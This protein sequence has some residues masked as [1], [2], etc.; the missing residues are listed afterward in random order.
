[1]AKEIVFEKVLR[2][3]MKENKLSQRKT[4]DKI[5][6]A[7]ETVS[8]WLNTGALPSLY[9][10]IELSELFKVPIDYLVFGE[11]GGRWSD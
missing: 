4:A 11:E 2:Q 3:L 9:S 6:G 7:Q 8:K 10:L 5:G 1:M